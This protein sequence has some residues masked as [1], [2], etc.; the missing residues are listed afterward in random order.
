MADRVEDVTGASAGIALQQPPRRLGARFS[1]RSK[2]I[3]IVFIA[4]MFFLIIYGIMAAGERHAGQG[5][6]S[7]GDRPGQIRPD[8]SMMAPKEPPKIPPKPAPEVNCEDGNNSP[9]PCKPRPKAAAPMTEEQQFKKWVETQVYLEKRKHVL[10]GY[11]ALESD[12]KSGGARVASASPSMARPVMQG[13]AML[14]AIAGQTGF[15]QGGGASPVVVKNSG[16]GQGANGL[17]GLSSGTG[18]VV[19]QIMKMQGDYLASRSNGNGSSR[20]GIDSNKAWQQEMSGGSNRGAGGYLSATRMDPRGEFELFAGSIIPAVSVTAID[21]DLPGTITAQVRRTVYDS[22]SPNVVLIPQSAKL[23]GEYNSMVQ[24]GQE[25]LMVVWNEI[26]YPDG[27]TLDLRSMAGVDQ[28][29]QAGFYDQVNN[30][31][32]KI[33]GSAALISLIG[34]AAQASQPQNNS[35]LTA[36]SAGSQAI[37]NFANQMNTA[38]LNILNKNMN[39]APT[40]NIRPGYPF[41]VMVNRTIILE[42]WGRD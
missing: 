13:Q 3:V 2:M 15:S 25:R 17:S 7:S 33:F 29:G 9:W 6:G 27:S 14:P 32:M 1:Q 20:V 35:I 42:P 30:H 19:D 24:Y 8:F 28:L 36:P 23:V 40:L 41:N 18:G 39:I 21:S 16:A 5:E 4:G 38:A 10:A 26:I 34:A 37:G 22:R 12:V 31:Y 11:S